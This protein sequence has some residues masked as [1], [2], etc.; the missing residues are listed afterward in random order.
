MRKVYLAAALMVVVALILLLGFV[1]FYKVHATNVN[2]NVMWYGTQ[3]TYNSPIFSG[4]T[5]PVGGFDLQP[6]GSF[7]YTL[8]I[9]SGAD[10]SNVRIAN[11]T[12]DNGFRLSNLNATLPAVVA[13]FGSSAH[14][15]LVVVSPSQPFSGPVDITVSAQCSNPPN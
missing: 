14:I 4:T 10:C 9:R 1:T 5:F 13:P 15:A 11:I 6:G 7:V 3:P 8:G 12:A 2:Q